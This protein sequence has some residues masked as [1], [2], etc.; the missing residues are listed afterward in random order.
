M[1]FE[2]VIYIMLFVAFLYGLYRGIKK[3]TTYLI[4][5]TASFALVYFYIAPFLLQIDVITDLLEQAK[6]YINVFFEFTKIN[7]F[8]V[9]FF[10]VYILPF[11]IILGI[12][13][14]IFKCLFFR[15]KDYLY[16]KKGFFQRVF[17][18]LLGLLVGIQAVVFMMIVLNACCLV[19]LDSDISQ[20]IIKYLP[21]LAQILEESACMLR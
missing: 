15:K 18:A 5:Y 3:E 19:N 11:L 9:D 4:S 17:G 10:L 8:I 12:L 7:P 16:E 14:L 6:S 21:N 13:N 1:P 20:L 2:Y